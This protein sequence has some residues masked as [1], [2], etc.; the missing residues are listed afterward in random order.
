[1]CVGVYLSLEIRTKTV[2]LVNCKT[3]ARRLGTVVGPV[4][5]L[6]AA[7]GAL[8]PAPPRSPRGKG[9]GLAGARSRSPTPTRHREAPARRQAPFHA[10]SVRR[11]AALVQAGLCE[12]GLTPLRRR[13][14]CPAFE[15]PQRQRACRKAGGVSEV[16]VQ[17][18]ASIHAMRNFSGRSISTIARS[19]TARRTPPIQS[20]QHA[21]SRSCSPRSIDRGRSCKLVARTLLPD[22]YVACSCRESI[23]LDEVLVHPV[24]YA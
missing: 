1:V 22:Y 18:R 2:V 11:Y 17:S 23:R 9:A 6:R 5:A 14:N 20:R 13:E 3:L 21:S 4:R 15:C 16:L 24:P 12:E 10:P 7:P 19:I 8:P